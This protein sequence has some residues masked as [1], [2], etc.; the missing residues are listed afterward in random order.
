MYASL[1]DMV[2]RFGE[3]EVRTLTDRDNTGEIDAAVLAGGLQAAVDEI[4]GYI[5]GRYTL[6]L[7]VVPSNLR[8]IACDI[9]RYRLTGTE[10]VCTDEIRDRYRDAIRYL[11]N[12]AN[13][14]VTL[15]TTQNG[16]TLQ[17]NAGAAFFSGRR[18]WGRNQT[19]GGGF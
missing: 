11:E 2:L 5:G 12:V 7:P 19:G 4:N 16:G 1:E 18:I 13:G 10:R 9:A 6:P 8:G 15:A 17:G 3:R 14:R